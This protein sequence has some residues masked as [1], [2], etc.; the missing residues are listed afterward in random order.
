[1]QNQNNNWNPW[2]EFYSPNNL[3]T[4]NIST[5]LGNTP[6]PIEGLKYGF[7]YVYNINSSTQATVEVTNGYTQ[8][9]SFN[10]QYST[11]FIV[12]GDRGINITF[13]DIFQ[14]S[15]PIYGMPSVSFGS[16]A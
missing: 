1:M 6:I 14:F 2:W 16:V 11:S 4:S 13:A 5:L 15:V 3:P 8:F 9:S 7:E 12:D 10:P